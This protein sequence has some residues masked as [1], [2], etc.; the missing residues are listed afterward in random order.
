[1]KTKVE[2]GD[3]GYFSQKTLQIKKKLSIDPKIVI[4]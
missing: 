4:V 2:K 1:M 3:L